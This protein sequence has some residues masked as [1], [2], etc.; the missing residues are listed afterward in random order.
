MPFVAMIFKTEFCRVDTL[1]FYMC[2]CLNVCVR[3]CVREY[4]YQTPF[5]ALLNF[6]YPYVMPVAVMSFYY[7]LMNFSNTSTCLHP[8]SI[9]LS[10]AYILGVEN[11]GN[12]FPCQDVLTYSW[13][14][15]AA[16]T[17]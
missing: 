8:V 12:S 1:L 11:K 15:L 7:S 13:Q 16:L 4:Q 6:F 2:A 5:K 17:P 3:T 14:C 9:K 10:H